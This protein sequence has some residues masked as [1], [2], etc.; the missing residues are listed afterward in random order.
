M[1]GIVALGA[2]FDAVIFGAMV[3]CFAMPKL[4]EGA[5]GRPLHSMNAVCGASYEARGAPFLFS[6]LLTEWLVV[7]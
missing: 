5:H 1:Y 2:V 3:T 7:Q 6:V 4:A